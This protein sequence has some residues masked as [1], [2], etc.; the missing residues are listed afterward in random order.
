MFLKTK[1]KAQEKDRRR[2]REKIEGE[3]ICTKK[4]EIT[5]QTIEPLNTEKKKEERKKKKKQQ[6][7]TKKL[8]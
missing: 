5:L 4:N 8:K 6:K 1:M 3:R 7:Q 2:E